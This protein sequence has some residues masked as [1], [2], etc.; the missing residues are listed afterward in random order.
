MAKRVDISTFSGDNLEITVTV[1][2]GNNPP[3]IK[4]L[5]GATKIMWAVSDSAGSTIKLSKDLSGGI[6]ITDAVNG[7]FQ[8]VVS[9]ADLEPLSGSFYHEAK[10][11]DAA[12]KISTVMYGTFELKPNTVQLT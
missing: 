1:D 3:S 5:T 4:N 6:T 11:K 7:K 12:G 9:S 2:D 8:V 10:V